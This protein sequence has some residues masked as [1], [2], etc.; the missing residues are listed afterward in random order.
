MITFFRINFFA[1]IIV[2]GYY[3]GKLE[4]TSDKQLKLL[5]KNSEID[6]V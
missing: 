3:L 6:L 1:S 5:M 4:R 2:V